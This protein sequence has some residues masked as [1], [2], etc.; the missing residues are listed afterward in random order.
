MK[1]IRAWIN[2]AAVF[3]LI[4]TGIFIAPKIFLLFMPFIVGWLLSLFSNPF[5]C[6]LETKLRFKRRAASAIV[7]ISLVLFITLLLYFLTKKAVKEVEGFVYM[8]PKM[9]ENAETEF[10][11]LGRKW[12]ALSV[13]FPTEIAVKIEQIG[14]NLGREMGSVLGRLSVP[15]VGAVGNFA[16]EIP[17]GMFFLVMC[18]L[19]SYF[20][21]SE[22]NSFDRFCFKIMPKEWVDKFFILKKT[23]VDVLAGYVKA[24]FKI[25]I[26]IYLVLVLGLLFLKVQNAFLVAIPV[27]L[28]DLL[29]LFGTGTIL[30][31]W[32][33][34]KLL[35]GDYFISA[36]LMILWG[37]SQL[38]RQLIQ[39]KVIGES[40]GIK[41]LPTL[42]LLYAGYKVAGL[43]GMIFS[44]PIG[45][46][47]A[48]MDKAGFFD[49]TKLSIKILWS[50]FDKLRKFRED[51]I[52]EFQRKE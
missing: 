27:A 46:L 50:G 47:F 40:V 51:E 14:G 34:V 37:I 8:I 48:A 30:V 18:L 20:F 3:L 23:T 35:G 28:L 1:Y 41:P 26:W 2:L 7:L 32:A 13:H 29:P 49:N 42:L 52:E 15:T 45:M 43:A 5:V 12:E 33:M 21:V 38:I 16:Q 17:G 19:S 22:Q 6:F 25:E 39:P 11:A 9:W 31:P 10:A 36:G 24:Q 44:V 4:I